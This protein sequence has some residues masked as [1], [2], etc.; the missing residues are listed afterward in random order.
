MRDLQKKLLEMFAWLTDFIDKNGLKYYVV[1]GTMLGAVRHNGFIPW[2]DDIDIGMPRADYN[3]LIGLLEEP[4]SHYVIESPKSDKKDFVYA[5]AKFYDTNTSMTEDAR[6]KVKRGVYIDIFPL[7]GIGF[8][9]AEALKNFKKIDKRNMLLAMKTSKYRKARKWW[10]N[11]AVFVGHFIPISA[12]KLSKKLDALCSKMDFDK[13]AYGGELLSTYRQ[14]EVLPR[15]IFGTPTKY[16]F[17]HLT[18]YGPEKADE[19]LTALYGD[20]QKLPPEDKRCSAHDFIDL[21]L[22]KPYL[23]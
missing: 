12:K 8:N 10:K 1:G 22:N 14:K 5:F 6:K 18:V 21:D 23:Q 11:L 2:D 3:K 20:W 19:Y 4:I 17:E 13:C 9:K 7:D 15:E 16:Q